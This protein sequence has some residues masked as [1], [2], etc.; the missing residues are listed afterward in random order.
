MM[1]QQQ[2]GYHD[3]EK[4]DGYKSI[5]CVMEIWEDIDVEMTHEEEGEVYSSDDLGFIFHIVGFLT[6]VVSTETEKKNPEE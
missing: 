2:C 4:N 5:A 6:T 3:G 1:Q